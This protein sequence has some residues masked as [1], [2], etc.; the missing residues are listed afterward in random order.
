MRGEFIHV[1]EE[2]VA[3]LQVKGL[4]VGQN[5][6]GKDDWL[7]VA[8]SIE[9]LFQVVNHLLN[10]TFPCR[11]LV[12]IPLEIVIGTANYRKGAKLNGNHLVEQNS[13][14]EF[15]KNPV[16]HYYHNWY[17]KTF[18]QSVTSSF[19][20]FTND[21]Y[22][23]LSKTG[24]RICKK[25]DFDSEKDIIKSPLEGLVEYHLKII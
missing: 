17:K 1:I 10:S 12:V 25:I 6:G 16:L 5:Y 22:A 13:T 23:T 2:K 4:I 21:A 14:I 19:V 8:D 20:L 24:R 3:D 15:L 7:L 11:D 18:S 9:S